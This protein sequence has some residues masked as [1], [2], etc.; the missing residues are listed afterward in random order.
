MGNLRPRLT[1]PS[2]PTGLGGLVAGLRSATKSKETNEFDQAIKEALARSEVDP[3]ILE[4]LLSNYESID[5][6]TRRRVLGEMDDSSF[7]PSRL[8]AREASA[9][10]RGATA[11]FDHIGET[12]VVLGPDVVLGDDGSPPPINWYRIQYNGFHCD[13]ERGDAGWSDEVYLVTVG[14][15]IAPD[16]TNVTFAE[17]HP[18]GSSEYSNVDVGDTRLGPIASCWQGLAPMSLVTTAFEHDYGDPDKYKDEIRAAVLLALAVAAWHYGIVDFEDLDD[19]G[20]IAVLVFAAG[21]IAEPISWFL[22]T[23]DDQTDIA[24][25]VVLPI[26][27]MEAFGRKI[28]SRHYHEWTNPWTGDTWGEATDL[29]YH[30]RTRHSGGGGLYT[31]G[32]QIV[33]DPPFPPPEPPPVD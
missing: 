26:E 3:A 29:R 5:H 30:F 16:G 24:R 20:T 13:R 33:R 32:Y 1:V 22:D 6:R 15:H 10:R 21:L 27:K 17:T 7:V 2:D 31:F 25:T 14:V 4:R 18:V 19:V 23:D 12:Q 11:L 8:N 28:L 9:P